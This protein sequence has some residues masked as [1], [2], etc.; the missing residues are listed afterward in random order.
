MT[1]LFK[2][3]ALVGLVS[4]MTMLTANVTAQ[5][6]KISKSPT[7]NTAKKVALGE[8]VPDFELPDLDGKTHKLSDYKDKYVVIEWTNPDCP[9]VEKTY[10]AGIVA[11]TINKMK[12]MGDDYVYIA[13]NST[14]KNTTK[15]AVIKREKAFLKQHNLD[16]TVLID[17]DGKVG[18][19]FDAKH[20]PD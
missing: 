15:E 7:E 11:D 5:V 10:A 4:A 18:K 19:M 2:G 12:E 6:S 17:F 20:T 8:K 3:L 1:R 13:I 14:A 16:V 9:W